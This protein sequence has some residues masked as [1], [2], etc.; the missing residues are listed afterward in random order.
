MP[1]IVMGNNGPTSFSPTQKIEY[2]Y[3]GGLDFG[4]GS[5]LHNY[6]VTALWYRL[7][8]SSTEMSKRYPAWKK[9]D[10]VL[11]AYVDLTESEEKVKDSNDR[12]PVAVVVPISYATLEVLLTYF[13]SVFLEPPY[14]RYEGVDSQDIIGAILLEKVVELQCMRRK[15]GLNLHTMFRDSMVYGFGAVA[16]MW[17]KEWGMRTSWE[18]SGFLSAIFSAFRKTNMRRVQQETVVYEGNM[19]KNIDPYRYLPDPSVPIHDPQSGEYIGW[20]ET[21]S[22]S[23]LLELE[24]TDP[25]IF[26]VRYLEGKQ[27]PS[28]SQFNK[29]I[30]EAGRKDKWGT[31]NSNYS[32]VTRPVDVCWVYVNLIPSEWKL[33]PS[34]YPEKWLFGL[35]ADGLLVAAKKMNLDHNMFPI[36][37]SAPD[38]DGYSSTPIARME[39]VYGLQHALNWLFDSHIANV[40]KAINDMLIVDPSLININDLRD[41]QP[42]KLV[43]MRRAAWGRGVENA[44][45]QLKVEDVTRGNIQDSGTLMDLIAN[46]SGAVDSIQGVIRK[47]AERITAEEVRGTRSSA[48][49]RLAK[50][51]KI[52]SLQAMFDIGYM[53]ASHTQQLQSKEQFVRVTGDYFAE[54]QKAYPGQ[55]RI[56][57]APQ[58]LSINYDIIQRDGSVQGAEYVDIWVDIMK[59]VAESP[60]LSQSFDVPRIFTHVARLM[61]AKDVSAFLKQQP[62]QGRVMPQDQIEKGVQAGNLIPLPQGPGG[63]EGGEPG[64]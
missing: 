57:I 13:T 6:I 48:L 58:D 16:P 10:Q 59:S 3:P 28:Y 60:I 37:I 23:K 35:A 5:Q 25:T 54:L 40:R 44:V 29:T 49:S 24:Q 26:N 1:N 63:G 8:E 2:T 17:I 18:E 43:R 9:I 55:T 62:M 20:V 52:T 30:S 12:K 4:P 61:G 50:A 7:F 33:G 22:Y 47:T 32:N 39:L 53:F 27:G 56:K 46:V 42:G 21:T 31:G 38:F 14:F 36:A 15:V 41:P 34:S 51:A 45:K 19:L 64:I 11:T